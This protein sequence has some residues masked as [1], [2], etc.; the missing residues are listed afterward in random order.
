MPHWARRLK[1][2]EEGS[3][4]PVMDTRRR[5]RAPK[6]SS[7]RGKRKLTAIKD[8]QWKR[9]RSL[10]SSATIELFG[11]YGVELRDQAN[12]TPVLGEGEHVAA[13]M[14]FGGAHLCGG[15]TVCAPRELLGTANPVQA[16]RVIPLSD[17]VREL[18][19]EILG[20]MQSKLACYG[21]DLSYAIAV[22]WGSSPAAERGVDARTVVLRASTGE[23]AV[24]FVVASNVDLPLKKDEPSHQHSMVPGDVVFL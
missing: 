16:D 6:A 17:F 12:W 1:S 18:A 11:H 9:W 5:A 22:P 8:G 24:I 10:V 14:Y 20:G 7:V 21:V 3:N 23:V 15:L 19:N 13:S 2:A 4:I